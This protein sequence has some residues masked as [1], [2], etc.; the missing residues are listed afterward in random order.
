MNTEPPKKRRGRRKKS[1]METEK[2]EPVIPKKRGRKPKGGKLTNKEDN[3]TNEI[4]PPENVILHL[5]CNI[6]DIDDKLTSTN[7]LNYNP[8]MPP[9][10]C[11]SFCGSSY[12]NTPSALVSCLYHSNN[13]FL[14]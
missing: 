9:V 10:C 11:F 2:N 3:N 8:E 1:E 14:A 4:T 7:I 12:E 13:K 6:S 5:D